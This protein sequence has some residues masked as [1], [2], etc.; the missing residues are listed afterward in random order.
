MSPAH[1]ISTFEALENRYRLTARVVAVTAMRVGAGKAQDPAAT[2]QPI[3]RD[4][5]GRPFLPGSAVK[6]ALRSGLESVLRGLAGSQRR[7]L[8]SCDIFVDQG[9]HE[10]CTIPFEPERG[11]AREAPDLNK[12][13]ETLC[14]TCG[15]FGSSYFAGRVFVHDLP[16]VDG[17]MLRTEVRDGVGINRDL[18]TA[19]DGI[20]Y[21]TEVVPPGTQFALEILLENVSPL[22]R[23]LLMQTLAFLDEGLIML[24]GMTSRGLGRVRLEQQKIESTNAVR[25]L[26]GQGFETLD[27]P[28]L[29]ET[30]AA[31]LEQSIHAN[32]DTDHAPTGDA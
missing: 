26:R 16:L 32:R 25:L 7:G 3:M 22:Q 20:K 15:L 18:R 13:R 14:T 10:R 29:Q 2:D 19:Q 30:A 21:D 28:A 23:A 17:S 27:W 1:A 4:A 5:M 9:D 6:G 11:A 12:V 8:W 24:G 31:T